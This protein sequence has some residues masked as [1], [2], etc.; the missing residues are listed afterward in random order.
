MVEVGILKEI[1][2]HA[3]NRVFSYSSYIDLF[4]DDR[5]PG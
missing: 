3:R 5:P 4:S 1:T 2:G